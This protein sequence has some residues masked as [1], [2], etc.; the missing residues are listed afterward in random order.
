MVGTKWKAL[1]QYQSHQGDSHWNYRIWGPIQNRSLPHNCEDNPVNRRIVTA[2][3]LCMSL[4]DP[5]PSHTCSWLPPPESFIA[6]SCDRSI[7]A[8]RAGY[9]GIFRDAIGEPILAYARLSTKAHVLWT[10]VCTS[11]RPA[12]CYKQWFQETTRIDGLQSIGWYSFW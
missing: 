10:A 4:S 7:S 5:S 12:H 2:W 11:S 9:G 3:Q 1:Q 8:Q 6:L